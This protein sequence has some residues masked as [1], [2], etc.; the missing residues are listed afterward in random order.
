VGCVDPTSGSQVSIATTNKCCDMLFNWDGVK[1]L[2]K[3]NA[4]ADKFCDG[5]YT[6]KIKAKQAS[7]PDV[8]AIYSAKVVVKYDCLSLVN[9]G[10]YSVPTASLVK[11]PNKVKSLET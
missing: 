8:S 4:L 10:L 5:E 9:A 11:W 7:F 3:A 1:N 2:S 6:V